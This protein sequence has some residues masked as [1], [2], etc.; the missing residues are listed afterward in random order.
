MVGHGGHAQA[1]AT[2]PVP[3]RTTLF[4]LLRV[5]CNAQSEMQGCVAHTLSVVYRKVVTVFGVILVALASVFITCSNC[6]P[7]IMQ[8]GEEAE[9]CSMMYST[10]LKVVFFVLF[11]SGEETRSFWRGFWRSKLFFTTQR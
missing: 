1:L 10:A 11:C 9:T 3:G 5:A 4:A 6:R 7:V 8:K 2:F